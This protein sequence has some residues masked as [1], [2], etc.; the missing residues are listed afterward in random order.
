MGYVYRHIT[1][2]IQIPEELDVEELGYLLIRVTNLDDDTITAQ[3]YMDGELLGEEDFRSL[4]GEVYGNGEIPVGTGEK[5]VSVTWTDP[6]ALGRT[7]EDNATVIVYAGEFPVVELTIDKHTAQS[8]ETATAVANMKNKDDDTVVVALTVDGKYLFEIS[9]ASWNQHI[10]YLEVTPGNHTFEITWRDPD[11]NQFFTV[12][13]SMSFDEGETK[14]VNLETVEHRGDTSG[15]VP[16]VQADESS[17]L[18]ILI[19]NNNDHI[20]MVDLYV[21]ERLIGTTTLRGD[22]IVPIGDLEVSAG[23]HSVYISGTENKE[24]SG[25]K[26]DEMSLEA[27][28]GEYSQIELNIPAYASTESSD[29]SS[30]VVSRFENLG[31]D[32]SKPQDIYSISLAGMTSSNAAEYE[33]KVLAR[34]LTG[35]AGFVTQAN[36]WEE[37]AIYEFLTAKYT[38][39][40]ARNT[41]YF[42][43]LYDSLNT[44]YS[45]VSF[46]EWCLRAP[47]QF[48]RI[49]EIPYAS[50]L[51]EYVDPIFALAGN[52]AKIYETV[53]N[54]NAAKAEE[55]GIPQIDATVMRIV[56]A[57][58]AKGWTLLADVSQAMLDEDDVARSTNYL[59]QK[60][61]L[62]YGM[63]YYAQR[64]HVRS[65]SQVSDS[66]LS[67]YYEDA[68]RFLILKETEA[69][70]DW[71]NAVNNWKLNRDLITRLSD[72]LNFSDSSV[73]LKEAEINRD[74]LL[75][76]YDKATRTLQGDGD[77]L[78]I[79]HKYI[80]R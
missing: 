39:Q 28:P 63:A 68:E 50:K 46:S 57:V 10:E 6:D 59:M 12:E 65:Q 58:P 1:V 77:F 19:H 47:A 15:S 11:T 34:E 53:Y 37:V 52:M 25:E 48:S 17:T 31:L 64:L 5:T 56:G 33:R 79:E 16:S 66:N 80:G 20:V 22:E 73:K 72:L 35:V 69:L 2:E 75:D 8:T 42:K 29:T 24:Y 7:F 76:A 70:L 4:G 26:L 44:F 18:N 54:A 41:G 13:E 78:E 9:I 32:L 21:D 74:S 45:T 40:K 60:G 36:S 61:M 43:T 71:S 38:L 30:S 49:T 67:S 23:I 14:K 51:N 62:G 27:E 55:Y 3:V